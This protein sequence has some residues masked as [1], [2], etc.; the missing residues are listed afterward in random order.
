MSAARDPSSRE[1]TRPA[2]LWLA[3]CLATGL[4]LIL[5]YRDSYQQDGGH[6]F[7]YA[8]WAWTHP[9]LFV[10]V[11]QRPL[12]SLA[13]AGPALLGYDAARFWSALLSTAG[14]AMTWLT[15]RRLGLAGSWRAIPFY[16]LQPA[17]FLMWSDT[18]TEPLFATTL[19]AALL[20]HASGRLVTGAVLASLCIGARPE[21][22][23][24]ALV[25]GLMM[26]AHP[27]AGKSLFTRGLRSLALATGLLS[28]V[29]AAWMIS[30][31]PLYIRNNWPPDWQAGGAAYG[32]GPIW[33]YIARF[34]EIAGP[35]LMVPVAAGLAIMVRRPGLRFIAALFLF[36]FAVHS[37]MRAFG[38]FGSAGYARYFSGFAPC[39][40]LAGCVG[41]NALAA[42]RPRVFHGRAWSIALA[43]SFVINLW[44]VDGS[45][46][47]RDARAITMLKNHFDR[48]HAGLP[49]ERF[50]WS[51]AYMCILWDRDPWESPGLSG[52]NPDAP[53]ILRDL[54]PGTLVAWDDQT[55]RL[56]HRLAPGDFEAAGFRLLHRESHS[57]R[58]WLPAIPS[59][60][61]GGIRNNTF[62]LLYKDTGAGPAAAPGSN[63]RR[64]A[65]GTH[66]ETAP[67]TD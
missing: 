33:E 2:L 12:C 38:W 60:G 6:H 48:A 26:L 30:G 49:V 13:H 23:F 53:A 9:E 5:L 24:V 11:W 57:L 35:L 25:W 46:W 52:T 18:M 63:G 43:L 10:G 1:S 28:W 51:Q 62:Y 7:L 8:R 54:P 58:G 3:A 59:H 64:F 14:A 21:G 50:V 16:L 40:A 36:T 61:W 39:L 67:S 17:L 29:L 41:W 45:V 65:S 32:K 22:A 47:N 15:A 19:S 42:R 66:P 20:A 56:V 4:V 37:L 55:G 31:D 44:Y 34:P 27:G